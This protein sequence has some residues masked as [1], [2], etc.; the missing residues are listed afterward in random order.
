MKRGCDIGLS[1]LAGVIFGAGHWSTCHL[2]LE[3]KLAADNRRTK[4]DGTHGFNRCIQQKKAVSC[5]GLPSIHSA[6]YSARAK[7]LFDVVVS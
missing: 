1:N 7:R 6:R 5:F 4:L 3:P 2:H